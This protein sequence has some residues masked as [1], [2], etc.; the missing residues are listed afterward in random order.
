MQQPEEQAGY[1]YKGHHMM[2]CSAARH[3]C[4]SSNDMASHVVAEYLLCV[5]CNAGPPRSI[6]PLLQGTCPFRLIFL[7]LDEQ[8]STLSVMPGSD[9][10]NRLGW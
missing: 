4:L 10:I 9:E 1:A 8:D 7:L 6:Y 3:R 5:L 2:L